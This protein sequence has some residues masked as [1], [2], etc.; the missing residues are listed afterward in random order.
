MMTFLY[1]DVKDVIFHRLNAQGCDKMGGVESIQHPTK[2]TQ[3]K[4]KECVLD[5]KGK[6]RL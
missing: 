5:S 3:H 6:K 2:K 4:A 1:N